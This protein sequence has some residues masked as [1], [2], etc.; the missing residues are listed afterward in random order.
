M[1][2][3]VHGFWKHF[4]LKKKIKIFLKDNEIFINFGFPLDREV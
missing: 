4:Q 1:K 2:K 3:I